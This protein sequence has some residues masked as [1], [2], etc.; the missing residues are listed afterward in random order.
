[1]NLGSYTASDDSPHTLHQYVSAQQKEIR[2]LKNKEALDELNKFP[3][4]GY[5]DLNQPLARYHGATRINVL[6]FNKGELVK[7]HYKFLT[8]AR[9]LERESSIAPS[10]GLMVKKGSKK[11]F[12]HMV[13]ELNKTSSVGVFLYDSK[14][15]LSVPQVHSVESGQ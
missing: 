3:F 2:D 10:H 8:I 13:L 9:L 12:V 7:S 14:R 4:G 5:Q 11:D 1:M 6:D 15:M